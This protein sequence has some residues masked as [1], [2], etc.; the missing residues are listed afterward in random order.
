MDGEMTLGASLSILKGEM[1][2]HIEGNFVALE[3]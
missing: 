2:S 1:V 3:M